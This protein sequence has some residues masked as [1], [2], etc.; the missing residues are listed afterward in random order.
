MTLGPESIHRNLRR[1]ERRSALDRNQW[2]DLDRIDYALTA[3]GMGQAFSGP[4]LFGRAF[5]APPYFTFSSVST[6]PHPITVGVAEWIQDEQG[7]Y[8]GANLWY[9]NDGP[10]QCIEPLVY[11]DNILRDPGF[12]LHKGYMPLGPNG[13]EFV[14]EFSFGGQ[15]PTDL[16]WTEG[17][18]VRDYPDR[19]WVESG[20]IAW[21]NIYRGRAEEARQPLSLHPPASSLRYGDAPIPAWVAFSNNGLQPPPLGFL[22]GTNAIPR[23]FIST[24]EPDVGSTHHARVVYQM[25][26][27]SSYWDAGA[28]ISLS[29]I[30]LE[31]CAFH[32]DFPHKNLP[33]FNETLTKGYWSC[34]AL[35]GDTLTFTVRAKATPAVDGT[36]PTITMRMEVSVYFWNTAGFATGEISTE[37]LDEAMSDSYKSHTVQVTCPA[38]TEYVGIEIFPYADRPPG[39]FVGTTLTFDLDNCK[40]GLQPASG[41]ATKATGYI[42]PL[43]GA[44]RGLSSA[45]PWYDINVRFAG[46]IL[47]SYAVVHPVEK[48]KA[49]T[50][51]V[52]A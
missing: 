47:K 22:P 1:E 48:Q 24:D 17:Y 36:D 3:E 44:A 6:L 4:Y 27:D 18:F 10:G 40:L 50:H 5:D 41:N 52:L 25:G 51:V 9:R 2:A 38:G 13:E 20:Q 45:K 28:Q 19:P 35:G 34:K 8:V 32:K 11:G 49:P 14:G 31:M 21:D 16:T 12:E 46:Q 33:P 7:M 29:P 15:Q 39:H 30:G 43:G 26:I 37:V 42:P 23:W